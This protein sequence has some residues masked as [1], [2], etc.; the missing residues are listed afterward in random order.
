VAGLL[1]PEFIAAAASGNGR[2]WDLVEDAGAYRWQIK[3]PLRAYAGDADE[4]IP[5]AVS[6][7]VADFNRLVGGTQV[8]FLSAGERADHRASYVSATLA[9]KPWFD[10]FVKPAAK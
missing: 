8:E 2:F 5:P 6:R 10:G 1:R 4:A 9:V 7:M 3:T